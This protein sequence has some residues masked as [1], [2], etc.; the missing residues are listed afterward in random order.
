M[1]KLV[2]IVAC[3]IC[4]SE[5]KILEVTKYGNFLECSSCKNRVFV[6]ADRAHQPPLLF[7]K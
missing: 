6:P 7:A 1:G 2:K 3:P 5:M 4:E